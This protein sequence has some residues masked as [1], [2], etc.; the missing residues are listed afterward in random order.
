MCEQQ[1]GHGEDCVC[2]MCKITR[3]VHLACLPATVNLNLIS[4][5]CFTSLSGTFERQVLTG[6]ALRT[7]GC[8][9]CGV[10]GRIVI[11]HQSDSKSFLVSYLRYA[12]LFL[13]HEIL[14]NKISP[15]VPLS[16]STGPPFYIP[17]LLWCGTTWSVTSPLPVPHHP[18][19]PT[20]FI[21]TLFR[22]LPL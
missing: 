20:Y 18:A 3:A 14:F 8:L 4:V 22:S 19:A 13:S 16:L 5:T 6:K 1:T 15:S 17:Q 11:T 9:L 2:Q 10:D 7:D 21:C 12:F